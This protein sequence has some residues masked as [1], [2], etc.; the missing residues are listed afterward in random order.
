[1]YRNHHTK[2]ITETDVRPQTPKL[3]CLTHYK[4]AVKLL[5]SELSK[6][7]T[8]EELQIDCFCRSTGYMLHS[9]GH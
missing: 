6:L 3:K 7:N 9:L 1:M 8:T 2:E 5:F 4:L